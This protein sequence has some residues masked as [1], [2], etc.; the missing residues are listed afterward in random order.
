[1]RYPVGSIRLLR[2]TAV[3]FRSPTPPLSHSPPGPMS[4]SKS[5]WG[6]K[7]RHT[8]S[9]GTSQPVDVRIREAWAVR[10][11][12]RRLTA[13]ECSASL[14]AAGGAE[15]QAFPFS[16]ILLLGAGDTINRQ[17]GA[18]RSEQCY[19]MNVLSQII[20]KLM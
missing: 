1:M 2:L 20:Q 19:P 18:N 17:M 9:V 3:V 12:D 5:G 11:Q 8:G 13:Q 7:A 10:D 6:Y 15:R 14:A 16:I 4:S